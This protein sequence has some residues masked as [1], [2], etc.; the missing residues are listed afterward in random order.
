MTDVPPHDTSRNIVS[1]SPI[2]WVTIGLSILFI[3]TLSFL[4]VQG[5]IG[6]G[7]VRGLARQAEISDCRVRLANDRTLLEVAVDE[8]VGDLQTN[9]NQGLV[10]LASEDEASLGAVAGSAEFYIQVYEDAQDALNEEVREQSRIV[11]L[12]EGEFLSACDRR[13]P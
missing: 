2:L 8:A 5:E 4:L 7:E 11:A 1:F 13:Y 12:P 9:F 3:G 10:A 6:R